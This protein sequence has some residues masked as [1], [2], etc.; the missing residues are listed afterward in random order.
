[1]NTVHLG[2]LPVLDWT[3]LLRPVRNGLRESAAE[4]QIGAP[5]EAMNMRLV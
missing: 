4:Q 2:C 5:P 1:M 3:M